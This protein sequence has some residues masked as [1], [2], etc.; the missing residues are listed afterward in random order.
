[1]IQAIKIPVLLLITLN[2]ISGLG[3]ELP[4]SLVLPESII[5]DF[6]NPNNTGGIT[7]FRYVYQS[8]DFLANYNAWEA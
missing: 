5:I 7:G 1:M 2:V 3:C 4:Q 6:K 8:E